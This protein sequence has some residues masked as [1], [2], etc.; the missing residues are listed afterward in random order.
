M[1]DGNDILTWIKKNKKWVALG[2]AASI[3]VGF[4][5]RSP[6]GKVLLLI[7]GT[8]ALFFVVRN[9][10]LKKQPE[11]RTFFRPALSELAARTEQG[12]LMCPSCGGT[13][14]TA[15]RS[16]SAKSAGCLLFGIGF[17]LAPKSRVRCVTCGTEFKRG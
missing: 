4:L 5:V 10:E 17:L 15:K 2:I 14:F 9:E 1:K 7:L 11:E 3:L 12:Q 16:A 8:V 13:Q 6:G